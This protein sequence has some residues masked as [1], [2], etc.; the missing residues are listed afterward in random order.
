MEK[1]IRVDLIKELIGNVGLL[2]YLLREN[3][4][5]NCLSEVVKLYDELLKDIDVIN[6][7]IKKENESAELW[8]L[9]FNEGQLNPRFFSYARKIQ[10]VKEAKELAV[11]VENE[12]YLTFRKEVSKI[13]NEIPDLNIY[14]HEERKIIHCHRSLEKYFRE[15]LLFDPTPNQSSFL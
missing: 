6:E 14:Q 9:D 8:Q 3:N 1:T 15:E 11:K 4:G 2:D 12:I 13:K 5:I 10:K 7:V